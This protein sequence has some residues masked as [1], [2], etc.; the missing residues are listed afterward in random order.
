MS[1]IDAKATPA[2]EA[3]EEIKLGRA[4][5][6]N[7]SS[8]R[9]DEALREAAG[10][11]VAG[12]PLTDKRDQ[13]RWMVDNAV[14]A[15]RGGGAVNGAIS[16]MMGSGNFQNPYGAATQAEQYLN[17]KGIR[18]DIGRGEL[19]TVAAMF[20]KAVGNVRFG[21]ADVQAGFGN[22]VHFPGGYPHAAVNGDGKVVV[23]FTN[24]P[25]GSGGPVKLER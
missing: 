13:M 22:V 11:T 23:S 9:T 8:M 24:G 21:A 6:K 20:N 25:N 17:D 16:G 5:I 12:L 15:I 2:V 10:M 4:E 14:S 1:R 7:G 3:G 18:L 19:N